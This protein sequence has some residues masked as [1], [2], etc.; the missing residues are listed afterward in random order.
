MIKSAGKVFSCSQ[1]GSGS[2]HRAYCQFQTSSRRVLSD[3]KGY[4]SLGW[5]RLLT[6]Q[7][8]S[9]HPTLA[10][11]R[12]RLEAFPRFHKVHKGHGIAQCSN[13][14]TI[15]DLYVAIDCVGWTLRIAVGVCEEF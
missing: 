4:H 13:T 8:C 12:S 7:N 14:L 3:G 11:L 9:K 2:E 1:K 6:V 15:I 10:S 5:T